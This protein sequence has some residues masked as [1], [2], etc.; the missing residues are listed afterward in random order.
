MQTSLSV[1]LNKV[2]GVTRRNMVDYLKS[3]TRFNT[4]K[5][6]SVV[7][8]ISLCNTCLKLYKHYFFEEFAVE[9]LSQPFELG[10]LSLTEMNF[11][12]LISKRKFPIFDAEER[13]EYLCL[14]TYGIDPQYMCEL[15]GGEFNQYAKFYTICGAIDVEDVADKEFLGGIELIDWRLYFVNTISLKQ[16][17]QKFRNKWSLLPLAFDYIDQSTG[18]SFTD[19][20]SSDEDA[21]TYKWSKQT[22]QRLTNE[23]KKAEVILKKVETFLEFLN[24]DPGHWKQLLELLKSHLEVRT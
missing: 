4:E 2:N 3:N 6:E 17:C 23:W 11:Y 22:I 5:T 9:N 19:M 20:N 24:S 1:R 16:T 14:E 7:T 15:S 10:T 18:N 8:E 21:E 13:N 12:S